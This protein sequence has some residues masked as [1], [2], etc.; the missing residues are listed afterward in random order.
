M[1]IMP[2]LE[3][4]TEV[5]NSRT[6]AAGKAAGEWL[7]LDLG[8]AVLVKG[9]VIRTRGDEHHVEHVTSYTVQHRVDGSSWMAV[10]IF[11]GAALVGLLGAAWI[12]ILW[13]VRWTEVSLVVVQP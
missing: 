5:H 13:I 4:A 9:T 12:F 7:Q 2:T 11:S 3:A 6:D 8:H 1:W 10:P